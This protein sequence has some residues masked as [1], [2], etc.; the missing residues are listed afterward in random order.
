MILKYVNDVKKI[1]FCLMVN[2]TKAVHWVFI[3]KIMY[4]KYVPSLVKIV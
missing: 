1:D 3:L 4:A 2:V